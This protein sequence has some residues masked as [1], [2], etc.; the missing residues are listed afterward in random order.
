MRRLHTTGRRWL[1][2]VFA[3]LLL[4][5]SVH[6]QGAT[7]PDAPGLPD[8]F[9]YANGVPIPLTVS[10]QYAAVQNVALDADLTVEHQLAA[11]GAFQPAALAGQTWALIRLDAAGDA[12][13]LSTVESLRALQ[14]A[15]S[16][17][18]GAW[19]NPVFEY[20][21]NLLVLT[22]QLIAAFPPGADAEA[23]AAAQ[24]AVIVEA[25]REDTYLLRAL[26]GA[27]AL[28]VA[29]RLQ[30][31]GA[32]EYAEPNWWVLFDRPT[33][34]SAPPDLR[35]APPAESP[36]F[37]PNDTF[38]LNAWHI[39]NYAQFPAFPGEVAGSDIK[40]RPAWDITRGSSDVVIAI[41]D[42]GVQ[43]DHPDLAAKMVSP[44][45]AF[46][47][48]T[49]P[50]P[51][52]NPTTRARDWHGTAVAGL[53]AAVSHNNLGVV[54]VCHF[55]MIMPIRIFATDSTTNLLT[56]SIAITVAG[57]DFART[58]GA[59]I[60]NLSW[61]DTPS[62]AITAAI[63]Q[64][65]NE[66]RGGRGAFVVASAGNSYQSPVTFPGVLSSTLPGVIAVSA[67]TFC[68]SIKVK[69]DTTTD[70]ADCSG[71]PTWGANWGSEI[72]I[73]APGH[74][75]PTTDLTGADG[76]VAGDYLGNF[77]GTSGSAP[78]VAGVAGLLLSIEPN[79]TAQ[80]VRDRLLTT[81]DPMHTDGYDIQSG[82]GRLNANRVV[83]NQPT[84]TG[85]PNDRLAASAE[86]TSLPFSTT[87]NMLGSF[88]D[89]TDFRPTCLGSAQDISN[90]VFFRF[91][92]PYTMT[93]NANTFGSNF[94]S[95][96]SAYDASDNSE[97][98]C[99][100][101]FATGFPQSAIS[102]T[103]QAGKTYIFQIGDFTNFFTPIGAFSPSV[104][105]FTVSTPTPEP[106]FTVIVEIDLQGRATTP[107]PDPRWS[108]PVTYSY[109]LNAGPV[110]SDSAT[111]DLD[112]RFEIAN[113]RPGQY[114]LR[115]KGSNTLA[116]TVTFTLN[117]AG[118]V[119][120][121][122]VLR[123]GDANDDNTVNLSDFTV[124][125][126]TFG[127]STSTTPPMD[128]RADF[129]GDGQVNINDFSLL[130]GNF[131][132]AGAPPLMPPSS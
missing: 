7:L 40:A 1:A 24:G 100:D 74:L 51:F 38:H 8:W 65:T 80:Q 50:R 19:V 54:G 105:S 39:Y 26:P 82:W 14:D 67:S 25:L 37:V 114:T 42:N 34:D 117:S 107:R 17:A 122:G 45:D 9:Y 115:V 131:G 12:D 3:C 33:P 44:F 32:V 58:N 13:A 123:A 88:T 69:S 15:D 85:T 48:D 104:L 53:A 77:G 124:L 27:D 94:N 16:A 112:G 81:A 84:N 109:Q 130:A 121:T 30:E 28:T 6:A 86:F 96:L 120:Q 4:T 89:T 118:Q 5:L 23:L 91:T 90:T 66:G 129:N 31:S 78:I 70:P 99:N 2:A 68:D 101:D 73:A 64:A 98:A 60:L 43:T 119:V 36:Q 128:G 18:A 87:Q 75:L 62:S 83:R 116:N 47:N 11:R 55:C 93:V 49:D 126:A 52:D 20:N 22:N 92:A 35:E 125:A 59:S 56:G 21:D 106:R 71:E 132:T 108:I 95:V 63:R 127:R 111:T 110:T 76:T 97:M 103:A 57:I 102:F 61:A 46:A 41:L 72:G 79:F 29:N 113:L 10:R